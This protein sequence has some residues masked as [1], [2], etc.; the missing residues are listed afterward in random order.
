MEF[1]LIYTVLVGVSK[2]KKPSVEFRR[3]GVSNTTFI[4]SE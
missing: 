1:G 2:Y 4:G 3:V